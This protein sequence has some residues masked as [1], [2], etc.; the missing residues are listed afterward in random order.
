M[1]KRL[2]LLITRSSLLVL[3]VALLVW[4]QQ[5]VNVI[6]TAVPVSATSAANTSG[7]PLFTSSVITG[8]AAVTQSTSPWVVSLAS[9]TITGTVAVTQSTSPW[10]MSC[11]VGNCSMNFGNWAGTALGTPTAFGTTPGAVVAGSVNASLFS[12]TT[13][14]G[15]P[16]TF[17]VTAPT[18]NALGVNASLFVG[19]ALASTSAPVP[20]S[21][22]T[23][24]Q[25]KTNPL[26]AAPTDGTNVITA[27]ISALG[28]APTG[29]EVETV[30][31]V[32]IPFTSGGLTTAISQALTT[33]I[34]V[35]ASAG[36]IYGYAYS[37]PNASVAYVEYYNTAT[38]PGTIGATTNLVYE[39]MIPAGAAANVSLPI[40]I[41]CSSG[42][43]VA[44][45][46]TATG[47]VAPG[48]GLT[49]T[50]FYK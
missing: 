12:G 48:T 17:G 11:T 28:T 13:A 18:G 1:R 14:L 49:I 20:I 40:G 32:A 21:A 19:T 24:A 25:T 5:P 45:A 16:N 43:A 37:N 8:T 47:A 3:F 33:T 35:K 39:M 29:T 10:V 34:N 38:T 7:N 15:T 26:F 42:I 2:A 36:Q 6:N 30:Q 22:T 4:A 41:A 31:Q 50:T 27:A 9:T 23:A 46:T 44:V